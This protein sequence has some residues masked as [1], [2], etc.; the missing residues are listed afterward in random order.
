M[1]HKCD[2]KFFCIF[3]P[4]FTFCVGSKRNFN[5][6]VGVSRGRSMQY[7]HFCFSSYAFASTL[8]VNSSE[9]K[10]FKFPSSGVDLKQMHLLFLFCNMEQSYDAHC[11]FTLCI[12][13]RHIAQCTSAG[14]LISISSYMDCEKNFSIIILYCMDSHCC[15]LLLA[16]ASYRACLLSILLRNDQ[17]KETDK[18]NKMKSI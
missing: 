16:V 4:S 3:F 15:Q 2:F 7:S 1:C 18:V 8:A 13:V 17:Y 12:E 6:S 10:S 14:S 5:T 11:T 9:R